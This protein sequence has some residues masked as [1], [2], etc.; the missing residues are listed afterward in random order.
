MP[1][2]VELLIEPRWVLP[3]VPRAAVLE[4]HAVAIDGGRIVD[5]LP[6]SQAQTRYRAAQRVVLEEHA[7]LPGLVN[8]HVHAAM[9]LLRGVAEDM[10]LERW[11]AERIWP[12]ERALAGPE[13]VFA[14]SRLAGLEMLRSGVT[15]CNDMYFFP[16]E[17]ALALR[18][19]GMRVVVGVLAIELPTRYASDPDDYLRRGLDAR[20]ELRG[21]PLIGFTLAPHAGYSV[22]DAMLARIATL[23]EEL[24]LQ[25]HMHVHETPWE[26]AESRRVHGMRPIARL[27]RLGL[28]SERLIAV[29]ATQLED[30]E[31][32]LLAA[33]GASIAHC[34]S[35]N[36]KLA[37]GCA[38]VEKLLR[39]GVNVALGS[40]GAASSNRLDVL[41]EAALAALLAKGS[42]M[43][44]S[45]LP[46]WQALE[47]ATL[48][49]ARALGLADRIGSIETGKQADLIAID[50]SNPETLPVFDPIAQI[51]H[52]ADRAHVTHA[53]V[54][55]RPLMQNRAFTSP[56]AACML[57]QCRQD[58]LR[59]Q[60][61]VRQSLE[62]K[63][64]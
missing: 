38:P 27:D 11:L 59:W 44:A 40:D 47:C 26:V 20:D 2:D 28:L 25:V 64:K 24:D 54:A 57:E 12:L 50:L 5:L 9:T 39:A 43:D 17:A 29:H 46:D 37:S 32:E 35:S 55:G 48:N 6:G 14:G 18:A 19:T 16:R 42:S 13:F 49:G 63:E 21:D 30:G 56:E 60:N 45:A 31:I 3:V 51:V 53:W 62:R 33:R 36:L 7:L 1:Q 22:D 15:C 58:A 4:Q 34:P 23:A 41:R 52:G 8:S 61:L 10:P